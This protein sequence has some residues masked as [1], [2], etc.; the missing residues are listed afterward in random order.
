MALTAMPQDEMRTALVE[1]DQA[2]YNH[3]QWCE[4]LYATLMGLESGPG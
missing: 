2:L 3:E 1:L 4:A